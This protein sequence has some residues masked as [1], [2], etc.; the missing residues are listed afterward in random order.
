MISGRSVLGSPAPM[1]RPSAARVP[2][3]FAR[4]NRPAIAYALLATAAIGYSVVA[5]LL[6]L[7]HAQPQPEPFLRIPDAVYFLWGT[8]F[9]APVIAGS[10]LLASGFIYLAARVLGR[11]PAFD[12]LLQATA[13]ATGLGTLGTLAPDLLVTSPLRALGVI[14]ERGWEASIA[15]QSGG[16]FV[17]TWLTLIVYLGLFLVLYPLAT[18]QATGLGWWRSIVVAWLGFAVFQGVEYV[19]IR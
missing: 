5:Y 11:R 14:T 9:Y 10:W 2:A 16:W 4:A 18:R 6:S 15:A 1:R 8:F 3:W 12:R 13:L 19:F 7:A 17:F